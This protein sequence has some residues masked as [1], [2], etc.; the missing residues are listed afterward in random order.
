MNIINIYYDLFDFIIYI[1]IT[2]TLQNK[3]K[4]SI[5]VIIKKKNNL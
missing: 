2:I 4:P 1:Y 3:L 5:I